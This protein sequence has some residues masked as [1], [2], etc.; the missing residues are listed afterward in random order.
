MATG[1]ASTGMGKSG[2]PWIGQLG[3]RLALAFV[4]VALAAVL[5]SILLG[6]VSTSRDVKELIAGQHNDLAQ[7][8]SKGAAAA[9]HRGQWVKSD[10]LT[11]LDF[12]KRAGA[13]VEV[14][15][16]HGQRIRSSKEFGAADPATQI[17]YPVT[18]DGANV[19]TVTVRFDNQGL[20]ETI[21]RFQAQRWPSRVGA[22]GVAAVI[23]LI[24]ALLLSR[25]ITAPVDS[26]I[27]TA[28]ARSRGEF[29]ARAGDVRGLGEIQELAEAFDEMADSREEQDQ[30]RRN[31]V[32]DVAHELRT[33]IAV[34][35]AGH[36]A[37]LDGLTKATSANLTSLRDEVLRLARMVDDLQRLA[38]AEA[39]ALQLRLVPRDLAATVAT[40][41]DS[42][43]DAFDAAGLTLERNLTEVQVRCDPFRMHEV[44]TNL[45]T[46]AMKFTP[47]GGRVGLE[48]GPDGDPG[49][50]MAVL[51]VTDS[52]IGIP[53][54]ELPL[55]T[56]RFFR[57][58]RSAGIA[59]S[60]IGL[61][62][63]AELVRA[64][65]GRMDITSEPGSGTQVT[66]RLPGVI[67]PLSLDLQA[68]HPVTDGQ[69]ARQSQ[70]PE[71]SAE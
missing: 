52:G 67:S 22:A 44:A 66:I 7:A 63:V 21:T 53:A 2:R 13:V 36:E 9:Y 69:Q 28:R 25:R 32:A 64:H 30:V 46:N 8:A 31:L 38:S 61:T 47:S 50:G 18:H 48:A 45:L 15:S 58:Q 65:R 60:G 55:V 68:I 5:A 41:A 40:A 54:G 12:V 4:G 17:Q 59:G 14:R 29:G 34:L 70:L 37:M 56:Q 51:R 62:I 35:Q 39:A 6:A 49:S 24:V 1:S 20:G 71:V 26:L 10:L 3:L 57:G 42:L 11:L 19:G 33:P 43:A 23:A 27:E 16:S